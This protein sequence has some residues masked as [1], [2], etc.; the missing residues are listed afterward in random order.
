LVFNSSFLAM[1]DIYRFSEI[2]IRV[3]FQETIKFLVYLLRF[4]VLFLTRN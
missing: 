4:I 3:L 1:F 2:I